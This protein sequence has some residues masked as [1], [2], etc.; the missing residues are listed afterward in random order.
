MSEFSTKLYTKVVSKWNEYLNNE[1]GSQA[2]EFMGIAAVL[3]IVLVIVGNQMD[4]NQNNWF[5]D[6]F[7]GLFNTLRNLITGGER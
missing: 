6:L 2:V 4:T 3:I 5:G 1:R 7:G